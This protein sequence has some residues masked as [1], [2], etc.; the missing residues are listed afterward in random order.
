VREEE[1]FLQ[2]K[3]CEEYV[4]YKNSVGRFIPKI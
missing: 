1:V 2:E 4:K 3:Y